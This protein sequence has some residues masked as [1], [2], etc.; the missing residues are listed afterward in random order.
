MCQPSSPSSSARS[1]TCKGNTKLFGKKRS[2]RYQAIGTRYR[3]ALVPFR[4]NLIGC[5]DAVQVVCAVTLRERLSQLRAVHGLANAWLIGDA[6]TT[7]R[8]NIVCHVDSILQYQGKIT[9]GSSGCKR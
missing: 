5:C 2:N 9:N 6:L 3:L 1:A 4:V 8:A 7:A